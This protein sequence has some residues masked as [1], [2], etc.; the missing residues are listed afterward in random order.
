[1]VTY[2]LYFI[3]IFYIWNYLF[4]HLRVH[5]LTTPKVYIIILFLSVYVNI[6]CFGTFREMGVCFNF[7][8][9]WNLQ[10][11]GQSSW[12]S[13]NMLQYQRNVTYVLV[14][15]FTKPYTLNTA[16]SEQWFHFYMLSCPTTAPGRYSNTG[17]VVLLGGV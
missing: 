13:H 8:P 17:I 12:L 10:G 7:W 6:L 2:D 11:Q 1:M 15:L 16:D 5:R 3:H 4:I 14:T 9:M